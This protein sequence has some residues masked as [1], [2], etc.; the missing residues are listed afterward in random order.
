MAEK[1]A[2][3]FDLASAVAAGIK[4]GVKCD[5]CHDPHADKVSLHDWRMAWFQAQRP[6]AAKDQTKLTTE[7]E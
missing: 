2:N 3:K 7:V 4:S 6:A 5:R 1:P